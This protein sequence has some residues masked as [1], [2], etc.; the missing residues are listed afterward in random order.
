[1]ALR[2]DARGYGRSPLPGGPFSPVDDLTALLD[3]AGIDR[4]ALVGGSMGADV[5]L[6]AALVAPDRVAALAL[7][8]PGMIGRE[9]SAE[10]RA[11]G[12][13]ED[14]AVDAGDVDEVVRLNV[15]FWVAGPG[16]SLDDVDPE[17][18][19][20]ASAMQRRAFDVQVPAYEQDPPPER[21]RHVQPLVDHVAEVQAPALV[22]VGEH[23]A[24]DIHDAAAAL[25]S[26]LRD[27]RLVRVAGVGH[28]PNLER[29]EE[30]NELVLGF[31]AEVHAA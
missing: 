28:V 22:L 11:Y 30:F 20:R 16:R 23:D 12:E 5:A 31:L 19:D 6:E 8:P 13:A 27:V 24:A 14:A 10:V 21:Q 4:A 2:Y 9:P 1:M 25:E 17:V 26:G 18:V 3:V 15:D 7:A 29:P